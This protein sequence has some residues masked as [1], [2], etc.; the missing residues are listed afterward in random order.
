MVESE[1]QIKT[2][3]TINVG[4]SLKIKKKMYV[5]KIIISKSLASITGDSVITFNE[6]INNKFFNK[7]YWKEANL[8]NK[9]VY[10]FYSP[11]Y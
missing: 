2:G 7:F 3:I 9:K 5:E 10:I 4:V 1:T 6:I 8:F 11:F